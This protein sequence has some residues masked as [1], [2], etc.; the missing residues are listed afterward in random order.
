MERKRQRSLNDD[1]QKIQMAV[2]EAG[3]EM[4]NRLHISPKARFRMTYLSHAVDLMSNLPEHIL[5]D[6][7]A[8]TVSE[9]RTKIEAL[10]P[11]ASY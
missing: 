7:K 4:G 3:R 11:L 10:L 5:N 6:L 2:E 8:S 1:E 9:A